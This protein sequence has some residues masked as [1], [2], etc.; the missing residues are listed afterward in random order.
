MEECI[1]ALIVALKAD[2]SLALKSGNASLIEAA[3]A[4]SRDVELPEKQVAVERTCGARLRAA[5]DSRDEAVMRA[6]LR[7]ARKHG[8][9]HLEVF[10]LVLQRQQQMYQSQLRYRLAMQL[11]AA[12]ELPEKDIFA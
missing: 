6:A 2:L 9:E 12:M 8:A 1:H 11:D 4:R 5:L 3:I 7:V 10:Q